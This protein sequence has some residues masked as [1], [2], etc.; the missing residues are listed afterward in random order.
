M[1]IFPLTVLDLLKAYSWPLCPCSQRVYW[2]NWH[3]WPPGHMPGGRAD[4]KWLSQ[5]VSADNW[6][7]GAP[8]S[9]QAHSSCWNLLEDT[10]GLRMASQHVPVTE[11]PVRGGRDAHYLSFSSEKGPCGRWADV[12]VLPLHIC[13]LFLPSLLLH[14]STKNTQRKW[15]YLNHLMLP[16]KHYVNCY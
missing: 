11:V 7:L 3:H 2:K 10:N 16:S 14:P 8:A 15:D 4:C 6:R 13:S 5:S 1:H 9:T 12:P